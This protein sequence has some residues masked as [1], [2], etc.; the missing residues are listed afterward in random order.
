MIPL[1][2]LF[3]LRKKPVGQGVVIQTL[4]KLVDQPA[5]GGVLNEPGVER[6]LRPVADHAFMGE[7]DR[8]VLGRQQ[9]GIDESADETIRRLR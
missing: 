1:Q 4:A 8:A 7:F 5:I 6:Q 9:A 2:Q 3:G